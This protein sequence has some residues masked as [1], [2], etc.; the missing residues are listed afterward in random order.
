[1]PA[2]EPAF[3]LFIPGNAGGGGQSVN[4]GID[5]VDYFA[6]SAPPAPKW[7]LDAYRTEIAEA[8]SGALAGLKTGAGVTQIT[9]TEAAVR[10]RYE[11]KWA[12]DWATAMYAERMARRG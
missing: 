3:P 6:K 8:T 11:C 1:M 9:A 10:L 5:V 12:F 4:T 2:K 7:W